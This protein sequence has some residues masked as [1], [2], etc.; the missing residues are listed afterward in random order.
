MF[1]AI[2]VC[3]ESVFC[4]FWKLLVCLL[5][6]DVTAPGSPEKSILHILQCALLT[7]LVG[8]YGFA[9]VNRSSHTILDSLWFS[10]SVVIVDGFEELATPLFKL[11]SLYPWV[12][13]WTELH[14]YACCMFLVSS[15]TIELLLIISLLM[16][17]YFFI[18]TPELEMKK[19]SNLT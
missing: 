17:L 1:P 8:S 18:E 12:F 5:R 14:N 2:N 13:I 19:T 16:E 3:E 7:T 9:F 10:C 4:F 11:V 15:F 6:C